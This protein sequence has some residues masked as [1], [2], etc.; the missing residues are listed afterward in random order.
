MEGLNIDKRI[1]ILIIIAIV[2]GAFALSPAFGQAFTSTQRITFPTD[3]PVTSCSGEPVQLSGSFMVIFHVTVGDKGRQIDLRH[4]NFQGVKA[5]G[6][7]TGKKYQ[8]TGT[9]NIHN[10]Y[11]T[12]GSQFTDV[13]QFHIL[14]Q[15]AGD[16]LR[17]YFTIHY[18]VNSDG[19]VT[20]NVENIRG[21]CG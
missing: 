16:D 3:F 21:G 14:G 13:S 9:S 19:K 1:S 4:D 17:V 18:T 12:P 7:D 15:G 6:L 8:V 2:A 11:V 5:V 20:S 10:F